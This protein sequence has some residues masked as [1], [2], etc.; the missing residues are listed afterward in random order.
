MAKKRKKG[1]KKA[2]KKGKKKKD[3]DLTPDRTL[4]SLFEE[5][6]VNGIIKTAP[7]VPLANFVGGMNNVASAVKKQAKRDPLP[8]PADIRRTIAEYC[9]LPMGEFFFSS[10]VH[11]CKM[12]TLLLL[13]IF[14]AVLSCASR[15]RM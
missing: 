2:S 6:V 12:F 15:H 11:K 5:L 13:F 4:E 14:Q 7:N 1:K 3:K 10:L 8:G 9:V